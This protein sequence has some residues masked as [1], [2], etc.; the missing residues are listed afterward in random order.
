ME[1]G[2][3][4][5]AELATLTAPEREVLAALAV[6]GDAALSPEQLAA[7][8]TVAD[9]QPIVAELDRRG[10]LRRE[11]D[12]RYAIPAGLR[13]RFRAAWNLVDTGDRVLRQLISIARTGG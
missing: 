6:M 5:P 12:D 9:P 4:L 2:N 11:D 7:L 10:F 1:G 8:T 3:E 13:E